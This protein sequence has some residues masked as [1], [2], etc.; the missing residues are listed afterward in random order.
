MNDNFQDF[1]ADNSE[2]ILDSLIENEIVKEI[3]FLGSSLKI[4]RGIKSVRDQAYLNKIKLFLKK[5]GGINKEQKQR[6]IEESKK[7]EKSRTKFGEAIFTTIEQSDS[8]VKIEYIAI[9]FEAFINKELEESD[10]RLLCHIIRNSFADELIDIIENEIPTID[11][12]YVVAS[13]LAETLYESLTYDGNAEP[14]YRLSGS[15]EQLR[16]AWRKYGNK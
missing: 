9:A 4:I 6:I 5:V 16:K 11:L 12:K 7:N 14:K 13:G 15:S 2:V 10:L 3:P 8:T 1:L